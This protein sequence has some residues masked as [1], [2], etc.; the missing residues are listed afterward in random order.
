MARTAQEP[1]LRPPFRPFG[2]QHP[3]A[4]TRDRRGEGEVLHQQGR[5][6]FVVP[7]IADGAGQV[8]AEGDDRHRRS[9]AHRPDVL[10]ERI[11]RARTVALRRFADI[12]PRGV[13]GRPGPQDPRDLRPTLPIQVERAAEN[14]PR[15]PPDLSPLERRLRALPVA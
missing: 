2:G 7:G 9:L 13:Q 14:V 10:E 12:L 8:E 4:D 1:H 3:L 15:V 5:G 6:L 11:A